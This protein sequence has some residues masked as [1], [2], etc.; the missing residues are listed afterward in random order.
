MLR[1]ARKHQTAVTANSVA[2]DVNVQHRYITDE[3]RK[4]DL[5]GEKHCVR[6]RKEIDDRL[7]EW[8]A[9]SRDRL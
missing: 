5:A 9:V 7:P 6:L 3:T 2:N 4:Y 1:Y 8:Q